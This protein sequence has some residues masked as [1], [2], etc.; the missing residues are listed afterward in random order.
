MYDAVCSLLNGKYGNCMDG[1]REWKNRFQF[2]SSGAAGYA[3]LKLCSMLWVTFTD[4]LVALMLTLCVDNV[5]GV[6]R[7]FRC[8]LFFYAEFGRTDLSSM[9]VCMKPIVQLAADEHRKH[10]SRVSLRYNSET[11]LEY[12]V[13]M[14]NRCGSFVDFL[15]EVPS[16]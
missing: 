15:L 11:C 6:A 13:L 12:R 3:K 9:Y 4:V 14:N 1:M 2:S 10:G 8:A 7:A 16:I 5:L